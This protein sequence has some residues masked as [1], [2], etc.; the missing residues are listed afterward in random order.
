MLLFGADLSCFAGF[1]T[2]DFVLITD[3]FTFVNF[4][5]AN[6][7]NI[8]GCLTD[9]NLIDSLIP[10]SSVITGL[11]DFVIAF[12]GEGNPFRSSKVDGVG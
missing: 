6:F 5:R 8:G 2:D 1:A 10:I 9:Q 4:R 3:S 12:D 11:L 7:T